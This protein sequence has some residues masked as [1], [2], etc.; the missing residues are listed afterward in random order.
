MFELISIIFFATSLIIGVPLW[1]A[2]CAIR[3]ISPVVKP[4]LKSQTGI[5]IVS[6][7]FCL[8]SGFGFGLWK[9][10][11]YVSPAEQA[12]RDKQDAEAETEVLRK[13]CEW[14]LHYIP[15]ELQEHSDKKK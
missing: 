13:Y 14:D 4:L 1:L 6:V 9:T 8:F 7:L 3:F 12:R 2:Y 15:A 11:T 10:L 5:A